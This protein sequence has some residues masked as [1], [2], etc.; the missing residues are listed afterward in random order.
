M[1]VAWYYTDV[2]LLKIHMMI[3]IIKNVMIFG[4]YDK[5]VGLCIANHFYSLVVINESLAYKLISFSNFCF[6]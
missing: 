1:I 6:Y 4:S 2:I 3:S 5:W